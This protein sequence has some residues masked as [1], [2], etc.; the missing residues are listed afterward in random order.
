MILVLLVAKQFGLP[1]I[2][3]I[4]DV[5]IVTV[6][7]S[8][9]LHGMSAWIGSQAYANSIDRAGAGPLTRYDHDLATSEQTDEP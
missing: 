5:V 8:A 1:S 3:L 6:A 9:L 7:M 4:E 2:E